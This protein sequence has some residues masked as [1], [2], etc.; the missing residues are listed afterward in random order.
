MGVECTTRDRV[1]NAEAAVVVVED[2]EAVTRGLD[3]EAKE[4]V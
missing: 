2:E 1:T 4:V 3:L